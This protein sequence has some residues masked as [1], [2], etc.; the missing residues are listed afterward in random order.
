MDK[1]EDPIVLEQSYSAPR[2]V[3]WKAITDKDQM[4]EWY[5][6]TMSDFRPEVG[7]ETEFSVRCE[8]QDYVHKWKVTEVIPGSKIAYAWRYE[9]Y[10][11]NSTVTW[12]LEDS[13]EGTKL[14]LA[15]QAVEPFPQDNPI[16]SRESGQQGWEYLLGERLVDFLSPR[17]S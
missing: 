7:F 14:K 10:P 9:G 15:H 6:E 8:D 1:N 4:C 13:P 16:F 2:D 11:G 12:E 17:S 5:F 3:V